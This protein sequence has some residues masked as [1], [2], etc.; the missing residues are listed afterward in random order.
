MLEEKGITPDDSYREYA[1][2]ALTRYVA[3]SG[4]S[5]D[6]E[7]PAISERNLFLNL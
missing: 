2:R 5:K 4:N 7:M 6:F 3:K 1:L